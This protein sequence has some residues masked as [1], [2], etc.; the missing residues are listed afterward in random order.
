MYSWYYDNDNMEF[1]LYDRLGKCY[2]YMFNIKMSLYYHER[3][4]NGDLEIKESPQ[5][6]LAIE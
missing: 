4:M 1:E 3:S 2:Y 5:R 6:R